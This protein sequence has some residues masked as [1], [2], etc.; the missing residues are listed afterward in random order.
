MQNWDEWKASLPASTRKYLESQPIWYDS[1]MWKAGFC[2]F[3][4][5]VMVGLI[6]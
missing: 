3:I 1:D 4:I 2:G 6:F 5:G